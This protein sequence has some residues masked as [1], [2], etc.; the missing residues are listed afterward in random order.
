MQMGSTKNGVGNPSALAMWVSNSG[1]REVITR[2]WDCTPDGIPMFATTTKLK[3]CKNNLKAWSRDHFGNVKK[4]IKQTKDRL[5]RAEVASA[6]SGDFEE[7]DRLK[8]ELN[9]LYDKEEKMWQQ[10]SRVMWLQHGD[11]NIK[12]FHGSI[13]QRKRKNFIKGMWDGNGVWQEGEEVFS[14]MLVDSYS[15]LFTSS[16]PHDLD[17]I[18]VGVHLV[19]TGPMRADLD[20]PFSSEEVGQAIREVAPLKAPGPDGMPPLSFQT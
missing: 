6:K 15:Q 10:W 1:C 3:R 16:N 5:W 7:V 18:L 4:S 2:A 12:F 14:A 9:V 19:V 13:T 17:R 20:K 8:R 11:R